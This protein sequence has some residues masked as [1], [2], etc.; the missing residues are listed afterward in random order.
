MLFL[1][2]GTASRFA[3]GRQRG[4]DKASSRRLLLKARALLVPLLVVADFTW[5]LDN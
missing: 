2:E 4:L 1:L 5:A 3:L